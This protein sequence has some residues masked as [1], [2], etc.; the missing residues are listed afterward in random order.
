MG[1]YGNLE[2]KEKAR[3]MRQRGMSYL[4]IM[5]SLGL[6]KSTVSD[7]CKNI[8]LT[9][10]QLLVLYKSKKSGGLRGSIIAAKKKQLL[11]LQETERIYLEAMRSIGKLTKKERFVS[12]IAFYAAE[13]TKIDKGCAFSNSDPAI[14]KFMIDWFREFGNVPNEKFRGA[15]WLHEGLS[16]KKAKLFWSKITKIPLTQFYKTYI[17]TS[18]KNSKKI[19]KN[20]HE[21]GVF[22]FIVNDVILIRKIMG[23]IGG[24]LKKPW[25]NTKV[26]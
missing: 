23:W 15:L 13:G 16:E 6:P 20:P 17:A 18:K 7:W 5:R 3:E 19:R 26:H 8:F 9:K 25:Y 4:K 1:F 22:S 2:L 14:V 12:G 24:I 21:Y 10:D 11:R